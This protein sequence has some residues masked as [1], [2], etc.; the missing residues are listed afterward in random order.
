MNEPSEK[1]TIPGYDFK[2]PSLLE[3]A[4]THRTYAVECGLSYDNQRLE[5][6]GDAVIQL[7]ITKHLFIRYWDK[8]EGVLSEMRSALARKETLAGLAKNIDLGRYIKMGK[9]ERK[10]GGAERSS[11]L[12]DAFEAFIGAIYLDGGL[13]PAEKILLDF[14]EKYCP[15]PEKVFG[16]LNPKGLLQEFTQNLFKIKPEYKIETVE[17]PDHD[18]VFTVSVCLEGKKIGTGTASS[19]KAAET[20]AAAEA[21]TFLKSQNKTEPETPIMPPTDSADEIK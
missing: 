7:V 21:I 8:P 19:R 14:F 5:F 17:G 10:S 16:D 3:K 4:L 2:N 11:T 6:L 20:I 18:H 13:D 9:G 12:S 1:L 15:N